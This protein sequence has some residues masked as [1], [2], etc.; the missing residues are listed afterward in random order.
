[1][2]NER[3][4]PRKDY[5]DLSLPSAKKIIPVLDNKKHKGLEGRKTLSV[6]QLYSAI[7]SKLTNYSMKG[8]GINS[9]C[10]EAWFR[11]KSSMERGFAVRARWKKYGLQS[12]IRNVFHT[13]AMR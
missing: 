8:H 9:P 2:Q 10:F 6:T 4:N 11:R 1:V 7:S 5:D 3:G 13:Q 12:Q